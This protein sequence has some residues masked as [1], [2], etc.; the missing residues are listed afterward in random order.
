MKELD[1]FQQIVLS[2]IKRSPGLG[3]VQLNKWL[4][5]FDSLYYAF[6][7]KS[8]TG[9]TYIKEKYGPVPENKFF[10]KLNNI[11]NKYTKQ[12]TEYKGFYEKTSYYVLPNIKIPEFNDELNNLLVIV[13]NFISNKT[14]KE[15]SKLTHDDIYE[16]TKKRQEIPFEDIVKWK[17]DKPE[18]TN[19]KVYARELTKEDETEILEICSNN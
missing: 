13:V 6:H 4:F 11:L 8:F 19:T 7:K 5:L 14:A 9:C 1:N 17:I 12:D 10:M 3:K 2:L 15:L 18:N 16:K